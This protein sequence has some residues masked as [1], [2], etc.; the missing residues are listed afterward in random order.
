MKTPV[1]FLYNFNNYTITSISGGFDSHFARECVR[2]LRVTFPLKYNREWRQLV[3]VMLAEDNDDSPYT[4]NGSIAIFRR[5][6]ANTNTFLDGHYLSED[7]DGFKAHYDLGND[8]EMIS[9]I[10]YNKIYTNDTWR[11]WGCGRLCTLITPLTE[12]IIETTFTTDTDTNIT[13]ASSKIRYN[14]N[15]D[16]THDLF[17][18]CDERRVPFSRFDFCDQ[19]YDFENILS[20][21]SD[22]YFQQSSNYGFT[23]D[24][25]PTGSPLNGQNIQNLVFDSHFGPFLETE[26]FDTT[27]RVFGFS[28]KAIDRFPCGHLINEHDSDQCVD[29][30][31]KSPY[32]HSVCLYGTIN[33]LTRGRVP[34][35]GIYDGHFNSYIHTP[36]GLERPII[37]EGD[38]HKQFCRAISDYVRFDKTYDGSQFGVTHITGYQTG[39]RNQISIAQTLT[40]LAG[41]APHTLDTFF[42]VYLLS[43]DYFYMKNSHSLDHKT[44]DADLNVSRKVYFIPKLSDN[45]I[46]HSIFRYKHVSYCLVGY[47]GPGIM[48]V[49]YLYSENFKRM[50]PFDKTNEIEWST[51]VTCP[52]EMMRYSVVSNY[53]EGQLCHEKPTYNIHHSVFN[54]GPALYHQT[55]LHFYYYDI[56]RKKFIFDRHVTELL[57]TYFDT[58]HRLTGHSVEWVKGDGFYHVVIHGRSSLTYRPLGEYIFGLFIY[59][60]KDIDTKTLMPVVKPSDYLAGT[61]V[62]RL[63]F[64]LGPHRYDGLFDHQLVLFAWQGVRIE[65][66]QIVNTFLDKNDHNVTMVFHHDH[67]QHVDAKQVLFPFIASSISKA[68]NWY[69]QDMCQFDKYIGAYFDYDNITHRKGAYLVATDNQ[70]DVLYLYNM[71]DW[72]RKPYV[73]IDSMYKFKKSLWSYFT[74]YCPMRGP[75]DYDFTGINESMYFL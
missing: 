18:R 62:T 19:N 35:F 57:A 9:L 71:L 38:R 41:A 3:A 55:G 53:R 49:R 72:I 43:F 2:Y 13:T 48:E 45:F 4:A 40:K 64:S 51:V 12:I 39:G 15:M 42:A 36:G 69:Y 47:G 54:I 34:V 73:E 44:F 68:A 37:K 16:M 67:W 24:S 21:G 8:H 61:G 75:N 63:L 7:L 66:Y 52:I 60:Y 46:L 14:E 28:Y 70:S 30:Y 1:A 65:M 26:G 56:M 11:V 23:A 29:K 58:R 5:V 25:Y 22:L 32:F 27:Q 6:N 59:V 50:F 10:K 17:L 20:L 31:T 74:T 33:R